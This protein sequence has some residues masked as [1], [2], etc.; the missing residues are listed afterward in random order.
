MSTD[1]SWDPP[2][3]LTNGIGGSFPADKADNLKAD[4]LPPSCA[5]IWNACN[6]TPLVYSTALS[7]TT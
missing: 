7:A 3:L 1:R 6:F 4:Y 2:S 5:E